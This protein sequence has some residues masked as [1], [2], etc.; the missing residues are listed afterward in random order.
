MTIFYFNVCVVGY[1]KTL[2]MYFYLV[3]ETNTFEDYYN[4]SK[5]VLHVEITYLLSLQNNDSFI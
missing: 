1:F 2:D 5:Y 4:T 3:M